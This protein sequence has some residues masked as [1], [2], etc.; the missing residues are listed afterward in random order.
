VSVGTIA[1]ADFESFKG[2]HM[3]SIVL[4]VIA[5]IAELSLFLGAAIVLVVGLLGLR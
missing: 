5:Q 2:R 3:R 4:P 1:A